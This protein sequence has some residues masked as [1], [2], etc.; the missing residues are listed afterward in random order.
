MRQ[1]NKL[2]MRQVN[3]VQVRRSKVR[4][5]GVE[6]GSGIDTVPNLLLVYLLYMFPRLQVRRSKV[7]VVGVKGGQVSSS[8]E[9]VCVGHFTTNTVPNLLLCYVCVLTCGTLDQLS[10]SCGWERVCV[11]VGTGRQRRLPWMPLRRWLQR[12]ALSLILGAP[13]YYWHST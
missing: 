4:V 10:S 6:A 11:G 3:K 9:R 12:C 7:R 5:I 1:V 8:C 13:F 2:D